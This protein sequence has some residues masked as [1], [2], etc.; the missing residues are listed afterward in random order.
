MHS[1]YA[2][3]LRAILP[4]GIIAASILLGWLLQKLISTKLHALAQATAARWDDVL[5]R[6]FR[7]VILVWLLLV[8]L[9]IVLTITD[10]PAQAYRLVQKAIILAAIFSVT[11]WAARAGAGFVDLYITRVA[12]AASTLFKNITVP[13]IYVVGTLAIL[14]DLGIAIAP[15]ITALGAGGLAIARRFRTRWPTSSPG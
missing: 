12:G 11:V 7:G 8:G 3:F 1:A 2:P 5:V 9:S 14:D 15:I 10:L 4:A 13:I 6:S